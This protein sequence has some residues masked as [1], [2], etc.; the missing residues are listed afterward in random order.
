MTYHR[1][2]AGLTI[3]ILAFC[4]VIPRLGA[5]PIR[6]KV[7]ADLANIRE[8]PDI[9][10]A[11]VLQ[12]PQGA[13]LDAESKEGEWFKVK[14][15]GEGGAVLTGYVHESL[16]TVVEPEPQTVPTVPAAPPASAQAQRFFL[17]VSGSGS[18]LKEG[19]LN[20]G[21]EGLSLFYQD[22]YQ[23]AGT[24]E[25]APVRFCYSGSAEF[26]I[27]LT[28]QAWLGIGVQGISGRRESSIEL[29]VPGKTMIFFTRPQ[30]RS[31]PLSLSL[32]FYP[33]SFFYIKFGLEYHFAEMRYL[34][35]LEQDKAWEQWQGKARGQGLGF[36]GSAGLNIRLSSYLAFILEAGGRAASVKKFRG[37]DTHTSSGG[38]SAVEKGYLYFYQG[39][40]GGD[41][42][43]S[44]LFVREN[45]PS[46]SGVTDPREADLN[47]SGIKF[48]AGIRIKF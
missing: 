41:S 21:A 43:Y 13:L 19:D 14:V 20:L 16:V 11:M 32:S 38:I 4:I 7:T 22:R 35:R 44:F 15:E 12:V 45:K 18:L 8:N 29:P 33:A 40:T 28:D 34:Y 37:T 47:L 24:G 10:S 25:F 30:M 39:K 17:I 26:Q 2:V 42:S 9:G 1:R 48:S 31:V 36:F 5:Q 6:L 27:P 46:E 23:V 3:I